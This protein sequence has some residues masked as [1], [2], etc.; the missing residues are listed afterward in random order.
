M[1]KQYNWP[2]SWQKQLNILY[3]L[4]IS[5]SNNMNTSKQSKNVFVTVPALRKCCQM[6]TVRV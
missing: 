5:M 4:I 6:V 1:L 3:C 2:V